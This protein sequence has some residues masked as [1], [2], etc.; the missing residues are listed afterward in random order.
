MLSSLKNYS[1]HI[2]VCNVTVTGYFPHCISMDG[3]EIRAGINVIVVVTSSPTL[4]YLY[5]E[6]TETKCVLFSAV[7]LFSCSVHGYLCDMDSWHRIVHYWYSTFPCWEY[8]S[9][10]TF[11]GCLSRVDTVPPSGGG[12]QYY[13]AVPPPQYYPA[14]SAA[15]L[16]G[17]GNCVRIT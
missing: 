8:R 15:V 1:P 17:P 12:Y 11:S 9:E 13:P 5:C 4:S 14:V 3:R 16:P 7:L 6:V 2:S 10:H